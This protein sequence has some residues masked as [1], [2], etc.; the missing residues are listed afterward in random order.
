MSEKKYVFVTEAGE[1]KELQFAFI[2]LV[3]RG[4][5]P[6]WIKVTM[7]L[8]QS[9]TNGRG[10]ELVPRKEPLYIVARDPE[11]LDPKS[12]VLTLRRGMEVVK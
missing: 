2:Q 7:K 5:R 10:Y 12:H 1:R 11:S 8:V 3:K 6:F 4:Y 9:E